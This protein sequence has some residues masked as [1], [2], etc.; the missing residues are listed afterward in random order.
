V[1]FVAIG[2]R[3]SND[4]HCQIETS[5]RLLARPALRKVAHACHAG[6]SADGPGTPR[7]RRGAGRTTGEAKANKTDARSKQARVIAMLRSP[8]GTT[9]AAIMKATGWQRHSVRGFLAGVVRKRLKLNLVSK[10]VNGNRIYQI[11]N[12]DCT[13]DSTRQAA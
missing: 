10:K 1:Q 13:K 4:L 3:F 2:R 7:P 11:A 9:I 8:T 12:E 6:E 5:D